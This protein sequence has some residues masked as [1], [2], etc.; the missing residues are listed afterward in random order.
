MLLNA[1][2]DH[3]QFTGIEQ[4]SSGTPLSFTGAASA[5]GNTGNEYDGINNRTISYYSVGSANF[6]NRVTVGTPDE[7][8]VPALVCDPRANLHAHQ[9][10]N[11]ACFIAPQLGSPGHPSIGT[12]NL[13]Y[14][15][16]PRFESDDIGL[17][18]A[19]KMSENRSVQLRAQAFNVFNHPMDAFVQYD[20]ALYLH[21]AN[22]GA[23]P[24]NSTQAGYSSTKLG[25]RTVQLEAK[26]FF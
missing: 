1:V 7:N 18:K 23:A 22:Y 20:S 17:Y 14:I 19:F 3:W 10:F 5:N 6:D 21:Y 4:F 15:H 8:A 2:L 11:A 16:G 26:V 9:Y 13:P 25:H 12:Y 24:A